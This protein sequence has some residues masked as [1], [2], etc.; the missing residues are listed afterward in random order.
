MKNAARAIAA[1]LVVVLLALLVWD[2]VR[3]NS[4]A[5]FVTQIGQ[6]KKPAAP[7]FTLG[8]LSDRHGTWPRA[9]W[10]S[11]ADGRVTLSEL[12]GVPVVLNFW[13]S[14]CIPCREEARSFRAI[15]AK[16]AGRVA[17]LGLNAQD[18]TGA[19]RGFLRRY[20]PNYVSVRDGSDRTYRAYGT[21]GFPETY[22]IDRKGRA[23]LHAVGGVSRADLDRYVRELIATE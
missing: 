15:A 20:D 1:G 10:G 9:A 12:R 11:L 13:A 21:T 22:F 2:L 3:S 8:V 17:F 4:G 6:G 5:D 14:W 7:Q 19:A 18:L 16:Y 23:R